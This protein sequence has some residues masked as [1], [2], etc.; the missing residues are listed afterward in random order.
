M[1][2]GI[3]IATFLIFCTLNTQA[4]VEFESGELVK[5]E[6]FNENFNELNGRITNVDANSENLN[7]RLT[8]AEAS[9]AS[10]NNRLTTTESSNVNLDTRLTAAEAGNANLNTRLTATEARNT[11]LSTRVTVTEANDVNL[12]ARLTSS[13]AS[14][15]DLN[16][17][18]T[19]SE[20]SNVNL[21]TRL[22]ATETS[23]V[24]L[25]TRLTN[26]EANNV[27][28]NTRLTNAEASNASLN[29]RLTA[30]ETS[31]ASVVTRL[32]SAEAGNVNLNT[33]L[34]NVETENTELNNRVI[35]IQTI[36]TGLTTR[37]TNAEAV[38]SNL[39]TRL[40]TAENTYAEL[41]SRIDNT[42]GAYSYI[43]A[44][45]NGVSMKV[46][47]NY[48]GHY[49]VISPTGVDISVN[50]DGYP[51]YETLY[52]ESNDCS[53]QAY[54]HPSFSLNP[55]VEVGHT[56]VNPKISQGIRV[57]SNG[58]SVLY[59]STTELIKL[60]Y[61][62]YRYSDRECSRNVGTKI[63]LA[64]L[65]N[66][67]AVTGINSLPLRITGVGQPLT[68][69]REVGESG[70]NGEGGFN[71]LANGV[72]IGTIIRLPNSADFSRIYD[73]SLID[74][75]NQSITLNKDGS[76]YGLFNNEYLY[77]I[78]SDCIGNAYV[79]V[80]E[81]YDENWWQGD[82][83]ESLPVRNNGEYYELSSELYRMPAGEI[84]YR[85]YGRDECGSASSVGKDG[86][87]QANPI[88]SSAFPELET[89]ITIEGWEGE[90]IFENLSEAY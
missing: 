74:Y 90:T 35:N 1:G 38:D 84:S 7:T 78:G 44:T 56:Y 10:Q 47:E 30:S 46:I 14:S 57:Y 17:R 8:N 53:G 71:V 83:T 55:Q 45:V 86:F 66:A 21:N 87:K 64:V 26:S 18:L 9:N 40:T 49:T 62:S 75:P 34:A 24:N 19:A 48:T 23:S 51:S 67:P 22:T 39:N 5:A 70:G 60:N 85:S 13:E 31:N 80:L 41:N 25:N 63:A 73:V 3:A 77:Y 37:I 76:F 2:K 50:A 20:A 68:V 79:R 54:I 65:A 43:D 32:T 61:S 16:T 69:D 89:P 81:D 4:L 58:S 88:G 29:T 6:D 36:T 11:S 72:K 52:Y 15:I 33:R 27:G 82:N 42:K 59:S 28:L 12:N